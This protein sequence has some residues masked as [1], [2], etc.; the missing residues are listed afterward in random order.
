VRLLIDS[1]VIIWW[2]LFPDR[3]SSSTI[4]LLKNPEHDLFLSSAT[5]WE[6]GIKIAKGHLHIPADYPERLLMDGFTELTVQIIHAQ[7][8]ATLPF[9]H[10]DPFDRMLIAQALTEGLTLLTSDRTVTRYDVPTIQA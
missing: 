3:L 9:H 4:D 6:L 1:H 8:A 10:S 2:L 5:V 7:K